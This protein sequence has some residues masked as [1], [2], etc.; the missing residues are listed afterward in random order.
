MSNIRY[1]I[2]SAVSTEKQASSDK[3]SLTEQESKCHAHAQSRGWVESGG[4]YI[5]PGE[6]RTRWVN[7]RDAENEI[8]A[9]KQM[10]DHAQKGKFD[11][12]ICYD[13]SRFR[14]LLDP[15]ARTLAHYR[16]QLL[17]ISQITHI[18]DPVE[19]DPY[20]DDA[21]MMMRTLYQ[22][23]SRTEIHTMRRR[24]RTGMPN[25]IAKGLPPNRIPYGYRKPLGQEH[26]PNAI[27][28]ID[29]LTSLHVREM[30]KLFLEGKSSYV[31]AKHLNSK[32]IRPPR[33]KNDTSKWNHDTIVT[34][35][36]NPF[37]AGIVRWGVEK[38]ALDPR[39]GRSTPSKNDPKNIHRAKGAHEPLWDENML[40]V[41]MAEM[42]RRRTTGY[43]ARKTHN[44]SSL[45][46]CGSCGSRLY[47][48]NWK[49]KTHY[50]RCKGKDCPKHVII[51]IDE[52]D[53]AVGE[54]LSSALNGEQPI[55]APQQELEA[56]SAQ[57]KA[58]KAILSLQEQQT[59]IE[60]A[61]EKGAYPLGK[62]LDKIRDLDEQIAT[63]EE[64]LD[65]YTENS[66]TRLAINNTIADLRAIHT[67]LPHWITKQDAESVNRT[68][69][70]LLSEIIIHPDYRVE[71]KFN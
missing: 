5:V 52:A 59:R 8:P 12:L 1:A 6:S 21:G 15:I 44:L 46:T 40:A 25:R 41:I 61:Y 39:T 7:L 58:A 48:D 38:W 43:K 64:E 28:E 30:L 31:I 11:L 47:R 19:F 42:A 51:N 45:M 71:L 50:W 63:L 56:Q 20:N 16:V 9:L 13:F 18:V 62:F 22:M 32:G 24:H 27:P 37:Y 70:I 29:P 17:S 60:T 23:Q 4:P 65:T 66:Y 35:L 3:I 49:N 69:H 36:K 53:Q 33:P 55:P 10:L 26:N 54:A 67:T 2:W 68:L 57:E 34:T 14:D